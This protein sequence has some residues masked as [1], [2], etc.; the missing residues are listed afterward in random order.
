M[1]TFKV[2]IP[3][4]IAFTECEVF[5]VEAESQEEALSKF[6]E[7]NNTW[8]GEFRLRGDYE[9]MEIYDTEVEEIKQMEVVWKHFKSLEQSQ[10]NTL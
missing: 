1:K 6:I 7:E 2:S 10:R 9:T 8:V 4:R 5:Y 3:R